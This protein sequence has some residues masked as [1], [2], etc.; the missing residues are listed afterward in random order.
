[1]P[2]V[3]ITQEANLD[4]SSAASWGEIEFLTKEDVSSIRQSLKNE[5][6]VHELR[7]KLM[8]F[9]PDEDYII[10]AGSP[11]V[12]ALVFYLLGR[13]WRVRQIRMLR[14]SSRNRLYGPLIVD[15]GE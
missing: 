14:W 5:A 10:A 1:M 7:H 15:I 13:Y 11:Y 3:F 6:L 4:F 9:N 2:K 12:T 8:K